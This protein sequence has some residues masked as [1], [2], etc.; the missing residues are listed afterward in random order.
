M[1]ND[2]GASKAFR[3]DSAHSPRC[4]KKRWNGEK[5]T[6]AL[7]WSSVVLNSLQRPISFSHSLGVRFDFC[8]QSLFLSRQ[9]DAP[10]RHLFAQSWAGV[11]KPRLAGRMGTDKERKGPSF[12]WLLLR[13]PTRDNP[14][15]LGACYLVPTLAFCTFY[16]REKPIAY[17]LALGIS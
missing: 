2:L 7:R 17:C 4:K 11:A 8:G 13:R 9:W 6:T 12:F 10:R 14:C 5:R 15:C 16:L 1:E 3:L